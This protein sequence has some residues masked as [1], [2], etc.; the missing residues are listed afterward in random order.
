MPELNRDSYHGVDPANVTP[1][2]H[3][4]VG[5][6]G[7]EFYFNEVA[8]KDYCRIVF[9]GDRQKE[10]NQPVREVDQRRF[11]QQWSLYQQGKSQLGDQMSLKSWAKIDPGSASMYESYLFV[12]TVEQLAHFPDGNMINVPAGQKQLLRRHRD[13]AREYVRTKQESAGFNKAISAAEQ[14][15]QVAER[16][17][18]ENSELRQQMADLQARL[19]TQ[20]RPRARTAPKTEAPFPAYAGG[21]G[22][23]A[24]YSLS[25][26]DVVI[27]KAKAVEAENALQEKLAH[28]LAQGGAEGS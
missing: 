16:A 19:E 3:E 24:Q 26:G 15:Q 8:Q 11:P 7:V 17:L 28:E 18:A 6:V 23:A 13:M 12:K 4:D 10:W 14:S 5:A 22:R 25:N 2:A 1:G 27:G 21:K 20:S 9:P